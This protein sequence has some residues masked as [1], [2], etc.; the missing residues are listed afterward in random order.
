MTVN[1]NGTINTAIGDIVPT[2][3]R[4]NYLINGNFD[5]WNYGTSQTTN[6][7]GSDDRWYNRHVGS[8]KTHSLVYATNTER[9][10]FSSSKFS[11]VVVTSV[12]G[13]GNEV[14][15][16]QGIEDVTKLAGKKVTVSFWAKADISKNIAIEFLQTFG[17]G[18]S[19]STA[20]ASIGSQLVALTTTWQ[21]KT[22][23]VTMPSIV[24]KTLGTD[25]VHTTDTSISIWF[26]AGSSFDTR[27][28]NL[29]Q[30]SG[31]FDI[32]EVK[33]EDGSVATDGW[34]PYDGEF[35]GEV[36][37]CQRYYV[38]GNGTYFNSRTGIA[39]TTSR[40]LFQNTSF[41]TMRAV[42]T[43]TLLSPINNVVGK[44][45]VYNNASVD[46]GSGFTG[47]VTNDTSL[48]AYT[49]GSASLTVGTYY[50]FNLTLSAEL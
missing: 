20:V 10:L 34:H 5:Q 17:T 12:A 40:I 27:A 23:T 39:V 48:K 28:A 22:I 16:Y 4:K 36:Q 38:S 42:P 41:N 35:G 43:V 21:K 2:Q 11:R 50:A 7:Y 29:G 37:A 47:D 45:A 44:V 24:G 46:V 1:G 13:A 32:A 8:T 19:P 9:A 31:T 26:D 14:R 33:I 49:D 18:G 25:G 3:N 15:K 6:G 30:Q